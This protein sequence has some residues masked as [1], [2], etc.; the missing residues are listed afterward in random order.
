MK[1]IFSYRGSMT[2]NS[3]IILKE[4]RK[5]ISKNKNKKKKKNKERKKKNPLKRI[6][7]YTVSKMEHWITVKNDER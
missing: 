1:G 7:S 2:T 5:N 4:M 3:V 6:Q